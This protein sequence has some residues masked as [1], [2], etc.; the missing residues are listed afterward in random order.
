MN[1]GGRLVIMIYGSVDKVGALPESLRKRVLEVLDGEW[2]WERYHACGCRYG[3]SQELWGR[4]I[5]NIYTSP[6]PPLR[7]MTLTSTYHETAVT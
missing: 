5:G 3:C 1:C 4:Q 6:L 7:D 2:T